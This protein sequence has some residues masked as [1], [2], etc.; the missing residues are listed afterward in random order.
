MLCIAEYRTRPAAEEVPEMGS[1]VHLLYLV[2][3]AFVVA[4][5]LVVVVVETLV[6]AVAE[7]LVVVGGEN[8]V[9]VAGSLAAVGIARSPVDVGIDSIAL[10]RYQMLPSRAL[11]WSRRESGRDVE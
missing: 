9:V 1:E 4:E 5:N 8:L 6:V 2:S 11:C 10:V 7:I 3:D